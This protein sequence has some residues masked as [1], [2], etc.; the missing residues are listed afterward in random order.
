MTM[1]HNFANGQTD[2][3]HPKVANEA[4]YKG[5]IK[6]ME[7]PAY[8]W[9]LA[10]AYWAFGD[11]IWLA[12]LLTLLISIGTLYFAYRLGNSLFGHSGY[13]FLLAWVF[14]WSPLFF[15]YS[16]NPIPDNL[17]LMA[18]MGFLAYWFRWL[19]KGKTL[20]LI[21][22]AILLA[23]AVATKLPFIA[24]GAIP[25]VYGLQQVFRKEGKAPISGMIETWLPF[26]VCI[27]WPL[28]W[29]G[30]VMHTWEKDGL[31]AGVT[32]AEG[33]QIGQLGW[34]LWRI[35]TSIF[36]ELL[37]NF[38]SLLFFLL[39]LGYVFGKKRWQNRHY[40]PL[41]GVLILLMAYLLFELNLITT[42]HDYYLMPFLPLIFMVVVK[43]LGWILEG[44]TKILVYLAAILLFALPVLATLRA[45][46]RWTLPRNLGYHPDYLAHQ[47][48]LAGAV[49]PN[50]KCLVAT[51][52]TPYALL[53]LLR[54]QGANV[55]PKG[56]RPW[57]WQL[58]RKEHWG[59]LYS[60]S[61]DFERQPQIQAS[62]GDTV[63][64][65]GEI[66]VFQLRWD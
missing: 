62:L 60:D 51:D 15:Y 42:A 8:S 66:I 26:A 16:V 11:H 38:G 48:A 33:D 17:A 19:Q 3:L 21:S 23:L 57:I 4:F 6:R 7:F 10:S 43:G 54:K 58:A 2:L 64:Q 53:Y 49:P 39:G 37:L 13:G 45:Y 34:Y 31:L 61:R 47:Q 59:Y 65:K 41:M 25:F 52:G 36:P 40:W 30:S 20:S 22:S 56:L 35:A 12:R 1:V 29:Y 24:W 46:P 55:E 63:L 14:A 44:K 28:A 50:A 32:Q 18:S 5:G 9:F 27:A